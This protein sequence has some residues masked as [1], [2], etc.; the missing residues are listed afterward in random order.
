MARALEL[1][2]GGSARM[3]LE[4]L[5]DHHEKAYVRERAAAVLKVAGGM[6]I[7]EVARSGLLRKRHA[8]TVCQWLQRYRAEG[9]AGLLIREG[10]GRK[11]AFFPPVRQLRGGSGGDAAP[12]A[13]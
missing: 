3:E 5:R 13:P 8:E 6:S 7:R 12:G 11:P 1:E 4:R 9:A 2:L 10:R